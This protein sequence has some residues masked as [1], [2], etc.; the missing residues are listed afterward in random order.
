MLSTA[1]SRG[2]GDHIIWTFCIHV[3]IGAAA[4]AAATEVEMVVET[5]LLGWW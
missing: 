3:G 2:W 1:P 4:A 5:V